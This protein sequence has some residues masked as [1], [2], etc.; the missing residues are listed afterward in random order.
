MYVIVSY[1]ISDDTL[2]KNI[3]NLLE[4]NGKRVQYSV[5]ECHLDAKRLEDLIVE[6]DRFVEDNDSIRIYQICEAC[7]KKMV[8]LGRCESLQEP[9]FYIV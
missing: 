2:R 9:D 1:D 6:L 5:F 4:D 8:M 3:A 7:L